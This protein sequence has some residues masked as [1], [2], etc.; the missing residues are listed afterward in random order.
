MDNDSTVYT[1]KGN[2]VNSAEII[3][4]AK[5]KIDGWNEKYQGAA[6][7][8]FDSAILSKMTETINNLMKSVVQLEALEILSQLPRGDDETNQAVA[9]A[10]NG[11]MN[12]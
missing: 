12:H 3:E 10:I 4:Y 5:Q 8:E 11:I 2:K 9:N 1:A 6:L 7:G